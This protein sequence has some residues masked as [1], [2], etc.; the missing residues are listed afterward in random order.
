MANSRKPGP[1]SGDIR[2]GRLGARTPGPLGL[3]DQGDP[4]FTTLMGDSP[5]HSG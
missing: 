5:V 4:N 1:L 3:L 2:F